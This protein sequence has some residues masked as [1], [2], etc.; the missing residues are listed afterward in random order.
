MKIDTEIRHVTKPGADLFPGAGF[1]VGRGQAHYR[2]ARGNAEPGWKTSQVGD[3]MT[4]R[5]WTAAVRGVS[6]MGTPKSPDGQPTSL[7]ST[8]EVYGDRTPVPRKIVQ[9]ESRH[10]LLATSETQAVIIFHI[11]VK[12]MAAHSIIGFTACWHVRLKE[13]QNAPGGVRVGVVLAADIVNQGMAGSHRAED[14]GLPWLGKL[15]RI[16]LRGDPLGCRKI[17]GIHRLVQQNG[18]VEITPAGHLTASH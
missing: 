4:S 15:R 12:N 3:Q 11:T 5:W 6:W 7:E 8:H 10:D 18:P 17:C 16:D 14:V 13:E 1:C 2:H 9:Q